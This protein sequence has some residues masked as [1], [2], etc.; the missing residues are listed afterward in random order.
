MFQQAQ[1]WLEVWGHP[2][3]WSFKLR[4]A[5]HPLSFSIADKIYFQG[6]NNYLYDNVSLE[7]T[8]ITY[9]T[10]FRLLEAPKCLKSESDGLVQFSLYTAVMIPVTVYSLQTRKQQRFAWRVEWL[11]NTEMGYCCFSSIRICCTHPGYRTWGY[12]LWGKRIWML[13]LSSWES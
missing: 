8:K 7:D 13:M 12:L 6:Y 4:L 5:P 1:S 10:W 11:R 2:F 3:Q 9:E